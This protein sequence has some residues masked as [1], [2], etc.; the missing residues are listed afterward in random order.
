M[1]GILYLSRRGNGGQG[2]GD[3]A[4]INMES[5]IAVNKGLFKSIKSYAEKANAVVSFKEEP[6]KSNSISF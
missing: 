6:K 1:N 2:A 4:C 3:I 5:E